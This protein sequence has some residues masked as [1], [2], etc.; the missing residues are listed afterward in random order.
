MNAPRIRYQR[1]VLK[2]SGESL[3]SSGSSLDLDRITGV[4]ESI[5][6]IRA[7]G[8]AV[9]V[10]VGGGNIFRGTQNDSGKIEPARADHAGMAATGVNAILLQ[11]VIQGM[12]AAAE[13]FSRGPCTGIGTPYDDGSLRRALDEGTVGIIAGGMGV[14][15]ISTDVPA[16]R[17]AIDTKASVVIMSKFGTKGVYDSDPRVNPD[18]VFMPVLTASEALTR[19]LRVMD[20]QALALAREF[21]KIIHVVPASDAKNVQYAVEGVEIGSVIHP[22]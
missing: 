12:D 1:V 10:V 9:T 14:P 18:A 15:G 6:A 16:V 2:V 20:T 5:I 13:I 22:R 17:A 19:D 4:A 3:G 8:V 21:N 11:A 7:A